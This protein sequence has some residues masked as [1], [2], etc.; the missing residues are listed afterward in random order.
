VSYEISSVPL[1]VRAEIRNTEGE[2][3]KEC[4]FVAHDMPSEAVF[5]FD[6]RSGDFTFFLSVAHYAGNHFEIEINCRSAASNESLQ[7]KR[8]IQLIGA[9]QRQP[10]SLAQT[11]QFGHL[12][13]PSNYWHDDERDLSF[14]DNPSYFMEIAT[15]IPNYWNDL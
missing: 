1:Y 14:R 12:N 2:C 9:I 6:N 15:M 11:E 5:D 4:S 3:P 10:N 8:E 7:I 13:Y